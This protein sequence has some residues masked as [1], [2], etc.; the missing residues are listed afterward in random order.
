MHPDDVEEEEDEEGDEFNSS[1]EGFGFDVRASPSPRSVRSQS[2]DEI[3]P[4][5]IEFDDPGG[6]GSNLID[7]AG[8]GGRTRPERVISEEELKPELIEYEGGLK[9][10]ASRGDSP[11]PIKYKGRRARV[12]QQFSAVG[13]RQVLVVQGDPVP[14]RTRL[15]SSTRRRRR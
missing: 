10:Q 2:E 1:D 7:S 11:T 9:P 12:E 14:N 6:M 15:R 4:M 8:L 5:V 3:K 13:V